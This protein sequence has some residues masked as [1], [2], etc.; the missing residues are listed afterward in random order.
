MIVFFIRANT[1]PNRL[2]PS[3]CPN[4]M[5]RTILDTPPMKEAQQNR[6]SRTP[7]VPRVMV[8]P[9][10]VRGLSSHFST[11]EHLTTPGVPV[12]GLV[13]KGKPRGPRPTS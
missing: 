13:V 9:D 4:M 6:L 7:I 11:H 2:K 5:L 12:D 1:G 3:F 8:T 10:M